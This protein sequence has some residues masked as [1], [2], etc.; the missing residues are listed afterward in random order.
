MV[1]MLSDNWW[2]ELIGIFC[3]AVHRYEYS[4]CILNKSAWLDHG[5]NDTAKKKIKNTLETTARGI[6]SDE[7]NKNGGSGDALYGDYINQYE[8]ARNARTNCMPK[9]RIS[10]CILRTIKRFNALWIISNFVICECTYIC[11]KR[12]NLRKLITASFTNTS[13]KASITSG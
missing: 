2:L 8:T 13:R 4:D 12:P 5:Y 9:Y 6:P 10:A 3:A 7:K 11:R 1:H